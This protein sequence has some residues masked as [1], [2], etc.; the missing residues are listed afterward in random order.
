MATQCLHCGFPPLHFILRAQHCSEFLLAPVELEDRNGPDTSSSDDFDYPK[1]LHNHH[2][3]GGS[4]PGN[5][6]I[7]EPLQTGCT[8]CCARS[9]NSMSVL[10]HV[11]R[12]GDFVEAR[13]GKLLR[14]ERRGH[15]SG[16]ID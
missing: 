4:N 6:E 10:G 8:Y 11:L 1:I 13:G 16:W 5:V 3:L 14:T 9:S 2:N 12:R 15:K 7:S